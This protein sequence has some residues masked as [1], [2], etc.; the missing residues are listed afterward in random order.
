M[1]SDE[2]RRRLTAGG[3]SPTAGELLDALWL[4]EH[5]PTMDATPPA[6]LAV[7]PA[8]P[9]VQPNEHSISSAPAPPPSPPAVPKP[10]PDAPIYPAGHG[11]SAVTRRGIGVS[12][13]AVPA[14]RNTL[15]LARALRAFGRRVDSDHAF[16]V[17]DEA[18][19][20]QIAEE[21]LWT[22]VL[23]PE[24]ERWLSVAVL[25]EE[26]PTMSVWDSTVTE[27]V[28][29]LNWTGLFRGVSRHSFDS[30]ARRTDPIPH[31]PLTRQLILVITDGIA[32]PWRTGAAQTTIAGWGRTRPV[33]MLTVLPRRMWSG[34]G[35]LAVNRCD[36]TVP[37][38]AAPNHRW[39]PNTAPVPVFELA[40]WG[41]RGWA[42]VSTIGPDTHPVRVLAAPN[43][44]ERP[45][46]SPRDA[47]HTVAMFRAMVSPTAFRLACYLSPMPLTPPIMRLVQHTMLPNSEV[48]HLAEV[49]LGGILDKYPPDDNAHPDAI[50]YDFPA[51]VR[52]ILRAHLTRADTF[53]IEQQV[54]RFVNGKFGGSMNFRA[55]LADPDGELSLTAGGP[56][57]PPFA[58]IARDLLS[59]LPA[60]PEFGDPDAD[61]LRWLKRARGTRPVLILFD[62]PVSADLLDKTLRR[63]F[64]SYRSTRTMLAFADFPAGELDTLVAALHTS[65]A[66][67]DDPPMRIGGAW[68]DQAEV[69]IDELH[70]AAV[71]AM[72]SSKQHSHQIDRVICETRM[73]LVIDHNERAIDDIGLPRMELLVDRVVTDHGITGLIPMG[74][75]QISDAPGTLVF[76]SEP[77]VALSHVIDRLSYLLLEINSPPVIRA[78][79][80]VVHLGRICV[81]V[82][83]VFGQAIQDCVSVATAL[84]SRPMPAADAVLLTAVTDSAFPELHGLAPDWI[85]GNFSDSD[86]HPVE[87]ESGTLYVRIHEGHS[88][89]SSATATNDS[90]RELEIRILAAVELAEL[91]RTFEAIDE[92]SRLSILSTER[93]GRNH[94]TTLTARHHQADQLAE[95][96]RTREATAQLTAVVADRTR[97]LGSRHRDTL[98]S[99]RQLGDWLAKTDRAEDAV[100]HLRETL[101]I[102]LSEFGGDD[103]DVIHTDRVLGSAIGYAGHATDAVHELERIAAHALQRLGADH[104]R[105]LDARNSV[106]YWTG[107]AGDPATAAQQFTT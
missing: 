58:R 37:G 32:E 62:S 15:D 29:M 36:V 98:L 13:P 56:D 95:G 79:R 80:I 49:L 39:Q 1:T 54:I 16:E 22:V 40:A 57:A 55:I 3:L 46:R 87:V 2:L 20:A 60:R 97:V 8:A 34:T 44:A 45:Q 33:A 96:G 107:E 23:R 104:P 71:Q 59:L 41:L 12:A 61:L 63:R 43:G 83:G 86:R 94:P 66:T 47:E 14:L 6:R 92:L 88:S 67:T 26:T 52:D 89:H 65:P 91:G 90:E 50:G 42:T 68:T 64:P 103:P 85:Q 27:F 24:R 81:S 74:D 25:V 21:G 51:G 38:P 82:H 105:T 78:V 69:G 28:R 84:W 102:G 7:S 99:R 35:L 5:L 30:S 101:E 53:R 4:A 48:V 76:T 75:H 77:S 93:L 70:Q 17:D 106:S 10:T 72:L 31:Q 19:A 100:P 9:E 18:T 11:R 73:I